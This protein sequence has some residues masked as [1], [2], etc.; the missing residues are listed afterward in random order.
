MVPNIVNKILSND[1]LQLS[2]IR[3]VKYKQSPVFLTIPTWNCLPK[4]IKLKVQCQRISLRNKLNVILF[5]I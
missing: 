5:V 2:Q 1:N 4:I 3:T